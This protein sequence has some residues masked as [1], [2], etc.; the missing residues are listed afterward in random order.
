MKALEKA[1]SLADFASRR[2]KA[3]ALTGV[4]WSGCAIPGA[5]RSATPSQIGLGR[6]LH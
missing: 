2:S 1:H 3:R 5:D 6:K 4:G